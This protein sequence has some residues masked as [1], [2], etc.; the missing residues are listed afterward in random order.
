M[1]ASGPKSLG[2]WGWDHWSLPALAELS[3][4]SLARGHQSFLGRTTRTPMFRDSCSVKQDRVLESPWVFI[5]DL[6]HCGFWNFSY[7]FPDPYRLTMDDV[8]TTTVLKTARNVTEQQGSVLKP[9]TF[10]T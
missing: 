8:I 6:Q 4:I 2:R 1:E 7:S 3:A 9:V 10:S 5:R